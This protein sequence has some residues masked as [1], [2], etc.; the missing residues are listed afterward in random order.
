MRKIALRMRR[1]SRTAIFTALLAVLSQI[2][3]PT[4]WGIPITLQLFAVVLAGGCLGSLYGPIS[5]LVYLALGA[6]GLPVFSGFAGGLAALASYTGGFLAS[7]PMVAAVSGVAAARKNK[8]G[9]IFFTVLGVIVCHLLGLLWYSFVSDLSAW[10]SFVAVSLPYIGKDA[11]LALGAYF[12]T[13][14]LK[15][16]GIA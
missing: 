16:R 7:F 13:R 5:V 8:A 6:I 15:R 9:G 2:A 4:P 11:L 12:L 10:Q 1:L 14:L 3:I